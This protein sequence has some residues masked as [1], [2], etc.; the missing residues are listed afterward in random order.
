[1]SWHF[2]GLLILFDENKRLNAVVPGEENATISRQIDMKKAELE[3][4]L[5]EVVPNMR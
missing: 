5:Y 3:A 4:K 2:K 1:M